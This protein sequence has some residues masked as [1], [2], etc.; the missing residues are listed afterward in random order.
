MSDL[1]KLFLAIFFTVLYV[2]IFSMIYGH[3]LALINLISEEDY[4][5]NFWITFVAGFLVYV[6]IEALS[7]RFRDSVDYIE[8]EMEL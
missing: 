3:I 7:Y 4:V 5:Y 1:K 2:F 8:N 6:A